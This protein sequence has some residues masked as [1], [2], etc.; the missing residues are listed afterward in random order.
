MN[1][2]RHINKNTM[3]VLII[4]KLIIHEWIAPFTTSEVASSV[5]L[6]CLASNG[7]LTICWGDGSW[8]FS[9]IK[10]HVYGNEFSKEY[11]TTITIEGNT[12][13]A[14]NHL[15][16]EVENIS[17]KEVIICSKTMLSTI[18]LNDV[19]KL[20]IEKKAVL[21]SIALDNYQGKTLDLR[22]CQHL[23]KLHLIGCRTEE[24]IIDKANEHIP[25]YSTKFIKETYR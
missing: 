11:E 15:Y 2:C 25:I 9:N 6:D 12:N 3:E 16:L 5:V 24:I 1:L 14:I 20:T 22:G 10:N 13:N 7:E 17:V 4:I 23:K 8:N 19:W 18:E 21:E